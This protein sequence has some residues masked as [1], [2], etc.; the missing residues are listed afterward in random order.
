MAV[1]AVRQTVLATTAMEHTKTVC[2]VSET[3]TTPL[4]LSRWL[5]AKAEW[6]QQSLCAPYACCLLRRCDG[7]NSLSSSHRPCLSATLPTC[8]SYDL[9]CE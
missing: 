8:V 2:R 6:S 9:A 1:G 3:F 4:G 7:R 5:R